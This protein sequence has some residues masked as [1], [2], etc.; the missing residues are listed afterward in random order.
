M[1]TVTPY[2]LI[3]KTLD[4]HPRVSFVL[5]VGDTYYVVTNTC[6]EGGENFVYAR[7]P[8]PFLNLGSIARR[9]IS[10]VGGSKDLTDA[11]KRAG[12]RWVQWPLSQGSWS[13]P[14]SGVASRS[15]FLVGRC[16]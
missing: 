4:D 14:V 7:L 8:I 2:D 11:V 13:L 10:S 16:E 9:R 1:H 15:G 6:G 5:G 3:L 12:G